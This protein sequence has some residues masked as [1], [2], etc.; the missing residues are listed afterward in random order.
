MKGGKLI[1]NSQEPRMG[2]LKKLVTYKQMFGWRALI[3]RCVERLVGYE[4]RAGGF[5]SDIRRPLPLEKMTAT[6]GEAVPAEL[7][8]KAKFLA[9]APL[10]VYSAPGPA[11]RVNLV[12][13]SISKG[14]LFGGVGTAMILAALIA[15][16]T[17]ARLRIITRTQVP[18][19]ASL[20][21]VLEC[22]NIRFEGNVEFVHMPVGDES[23]QLDICDGDTFLT[24]SWWSTAC[25]LGSISPSKVEYLLQE[26][27]RM[28]YPYGDEWL[29]CNEILARKDI[30]FYINTKLLFD[31]LVETGMLHLQ[32]RGRWF[33]PA[34]PESLFHEEKAKQKAG[35][36]RLFFYAR[37]NNE[38]N[39]FY[40]G[41]EVL[42]N[43]ISKNVIDI[44]RWEIVFVGKDVP[45][46]KFAGHL[47]PTVISTMGWRD[48]AKFIRGTD[49][50]FCLMSTPHPSYPP[51][52]L[53]SSGSVVV[54]NR[55]YGKQD[56]SQYSK[57]ILMSELDVDSLT[58]ALAQGM[59]LAENAS[60]RRSNY[61]ANRILRSWED[62]FQ[63]ILS[64]VE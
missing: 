11:K 53:A 21:Q 7:A 23:E 22:N 2:I 46:V 43:A 44:D 5:A 50:G 8:L 13:D 17:G 55:F 1:M 59:K 20:A 24:T 34:F 3:V 49:L 60:L 47:V 15:R 26:D 41:L 42:D 19:E 58:V 64:P 10:P 27:E 18:L 40:R 32:N 6:I 37:P 62:S 25:V 4:A 45:S 61:K 35:K 31:H 30:R 14:S 56:L 29:R 33:E 63:S 54:T 52:D 12:T 57:N 16:R 38:R 39:L 51:F 9:I 36:H 48:Y 28:F